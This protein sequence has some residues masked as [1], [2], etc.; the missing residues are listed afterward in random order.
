MDGPDQSIN[1]RRLVG[2]NATESM[3]FATERGEDDLRGV[4]KVE[5]G[6]DGVDDHEEEG[7]AVD[8]LVARLIIEL[9]EE[10]LVDKG[11]TEGDTVDGGGDVMGEGAGL[12]GA[13]MMYN[14]V[15]GACE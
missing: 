5:T 9:A 12:G 7:E 11:A 15:R 13:G 4:E 1:S 14:L 2:F 8:S 6:G 10:E 3:S